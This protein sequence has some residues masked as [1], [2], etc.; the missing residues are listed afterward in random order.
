MGRVGK[1]RDG[2]LWLLGLR[3]G[4]LYFYLLTS[5]TGDHLVCQA[6]SAYSSTSNPNVGDYKGRTRLSPTAAYPST[7]GHE[8]NEGSHLPR[9]HIYA[10]DDYYSVRRVIRLY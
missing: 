7:V 2:F 6:M 1:G 5:S 3:I 8:A 9:H 10:I 4:K